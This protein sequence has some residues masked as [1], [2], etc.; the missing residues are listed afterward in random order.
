[1]FLPVD[2]DN[3]VRLD[4]TRLAAA[5]LLAAESHPF[6]AI[7]LYALTPVADSSRPTFAVDENWRLFINPQ[8]LIDWS[9]QEVAGVLLHEVGHVIRDHA[10][11]ARTAIVVDESSRFLWNLAAD[12]EINDDLRNAKVVLP[13]PAVFPETLKSP[14]GKVAEFY[15]ANLSEHGRTPEFPIADCGAGCHGHSD[16][17]DAQAS[18]LLP[19]GLSGSESL[20]LRRRVAEA[21]VIAAGKQAGTLPGGWLRWAEATLRPKLNWRKLLSAAIRSAVAAVS[22][23]SDYSY[24]R[25]ARRQV[26][27]V[28]LP[29][30]QRPLPRVAVIVD[31]SG[32]VGEVALQRAWSEVHGCLRTLGVRRDLLTVFA[33]DVDVRRL[34]GPPRRQMALLGGGGTNMAL[35]I[36]TALQSLARPDLVV[37]ITDGLTPWPVRKPS[38]PVIVALLPSTMKRPATPSWARTVEI[39]EAETDPGDGQLPRQRVSTSRRRTHAA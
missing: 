18:A 30:M 6:L 34:T 5:R 24:R 25:P 26:P 28:V 7:A 14:V 2:V 17:P 27:R 22:G 10:G 3:P 23:A 4:L 36:E 15:Y 37:V 33:A 31:T 12:A 21:I 9:V 35:A 19:I 29:S 38:R 1:M 8:Q 20:L 13:Q 16:N 39:D 11:R 32:S